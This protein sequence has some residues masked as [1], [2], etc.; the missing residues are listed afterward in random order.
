MSHELRKIED[1]RKAK[2][3]VSDQ[4]LR[5]IGLKVDKLD[6][7]FDSIVDKI[8]ILEESH[9]GGENTQEISELKLQFI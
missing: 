8:S 9:Q 3:K 2:Q 6:L 7:K 4:E 1:E 5:Q